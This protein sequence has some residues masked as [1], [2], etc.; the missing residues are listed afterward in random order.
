MRRE[1]PPTSEQLL[2]LLLRGVRVHPG[3]YGQRRLPRSMHLLL[4]HSLGS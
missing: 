1:T 3:V 4:V 2:I